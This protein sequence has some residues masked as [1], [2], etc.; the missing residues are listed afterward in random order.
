MADTKPRKQL[1]AYANAVTTVSIQTD[2][3]MTVPLALAYIPSSFVMTREQVL[4]ACEERVWTVPAKGTVVK[5]WTQRWR[6]QSETLDASNT[7]RPDTLF[8]GIGPDVIADDAPLGSSLIGRTVKGV[9]VAGVC[10]NKHGVPTMATVECDALNL[11]ADITLVPATVGT[12]VVRNGVIIGRTER[13]YSHRTEEHV[14]D[15][16]AYNGT[17]YLWSIVA[18]PRKHDDGRPGFILR[19]VLG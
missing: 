4:K 12:D 13:T 11:A 16:V 5:G 19:S 2:A 9:W 3:G 14:A 6:L 8:D 7:V 18:I 1:I 17:R 10:S 15:D